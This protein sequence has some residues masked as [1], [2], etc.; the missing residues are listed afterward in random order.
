MYTYMYYAQGNDYLFVLTF[1]QWVIVVMIVS[2]Y[3]VNFLRQQIE[4]N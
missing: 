1:I 3:L 4:K 2:R